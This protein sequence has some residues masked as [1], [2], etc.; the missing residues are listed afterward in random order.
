[1]QVAHGEG[2]FYCNNEQLSNIEKNNLVVLRYS[3]NG[4]STNQYPENP[5]GALNAIAGICDPSGHIFGLMPHPERFVEKYHYPNWR[6]EEV[7]PQGLLI[8]E[9]AIN[10]FL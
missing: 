8:F 10:Y 1:M 2:K 9:R 3:H 7:S 4:R 6:H 5:N